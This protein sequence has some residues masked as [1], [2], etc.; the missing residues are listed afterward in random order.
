M[1]SF[2]GFEPGNT[3]PKYAHEFW[4][5]TAAISKLIDSIQWVIL[6]Y[7]LLLI[8]MSTL[9]WRDAMVFQSQLS[10][11]KYFLVRH[12]RFGWIPIVWREAELA[13]LEVV[14]HKGSHRLLD[15]ITCHLLLHNTTT[16]KSLSCLQLQTAVCAASFGTSRTFLFG[17]LLKYI[18]S[19]A[20]RN[21][22]SSAQ[23][24]WLY[25]V[26]RYS[27]KCKKLVKFLCDHWLESL[28]NTL[29]PTVLV[30]VFVLAVD[31]LCVYSGH[32]QP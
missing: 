28:R 17:Q 18:G 27:V 6:C 14:Q 25:F 26:S 7:V 19:R 4:A 5:S 11:L 9:K 29:P 30:N 12:F 13:E 1:D 3:S 31:V 32:L 2:L 23:S 15:I 21:C 10:S 8:F 22:Q 24:V 20:C 16:C